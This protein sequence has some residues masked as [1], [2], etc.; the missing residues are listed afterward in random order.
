MKSLA[1]KFFDSYM[2]LLSISSHRSNIYAIIFLITI[3]LAGI[4]LYFSSDR[5]Q[6]LS[7]SLIDKMFQF[8]YDCWD[9]YFVRPFT[10]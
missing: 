5:P 7:F 6:P 1:P 8:L 4:A 9:K 2:L 3:F 10:T